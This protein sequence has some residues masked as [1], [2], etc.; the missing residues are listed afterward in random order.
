MH[1][2]LLSQHCEGK[3]RV[4]SYWIHLANQAADLDQ[5]KT[6][7][8][9]YVQLYSG[10]PY[11]FAT[12]CVSDC[13]CDQPRFTDKQIDAE[14]GELQQLIDAVKPRVSLVPCAQESAHRVDVTCLN[15]PSN[16]ACPHAYGSPFRSTLTQQAY[17]SM[18]SATEESQRARDYPRARGGVL[19]SSACSWLD[20][21]YA[22]PIAR[23]FAVDV[24]DRYLTRKA[25]NGLSI[26]L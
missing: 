20:I 21:N 16:S 8:C 13:P 22:E 3:R 6:T 5:T 10:Q 14:Q 2:S 1:G 19:L 12:P 11:L 18:A 23:T 9:T 24:S 17:T 25:K 4:E 7:H 15:I 26:T